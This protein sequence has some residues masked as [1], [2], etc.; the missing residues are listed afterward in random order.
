[1]ELKRIILMSP[2]MFMIRLFFFEIIKMV[3]ETDLNRIINY[4]F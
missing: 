4:F 1:M 3:M 2:L